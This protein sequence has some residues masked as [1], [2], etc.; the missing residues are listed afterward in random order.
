MKNDIFQGYKNDAL[1]VL[2]KYKVR[3]W[4]QTKVITTR[5]SFEGTVLP[6]SE[7]DDDKHIVLK[8]NITIKV[9]SAAPFILNKS[10]N[11]ILRYATETA[12]AIP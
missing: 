4:G 2:K 6:R 9:E 7:N 10:I 12:I 1:E 5:G 8:T 3:V 11:S